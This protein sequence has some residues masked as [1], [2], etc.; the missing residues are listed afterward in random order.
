MPDKRINNLKLGLFTLAGLFF[1]VISLYMIGRDQNL[2]RSN[3]TIKAHFRNAQGIVAGNNIRYA[4]IQV[5][6]VSEVKLI[7][8]TLIEIEMLIDEKAGAKILNNALAAIGTEGLIGNKVINLYPGEGSANPIR[9]GDLLQV[10]TKPDTDAMLETLALTND[11]AATL[12]ADLVETVNRINKS[13]ALWKLL[14]DDSLAVD[15]RASLLNIR[16]ASEKTNHLVSELNSLVAD[17]KSGQGTAGR[18]LVDTALAVQLSG[19]LS[20]L[21]DAAS[22]AAGLTGKLDELLLGIQKDLD[23]GKGPA[24]AVL[25]D[26]SM[27]KKLHNSLTNIEK[28]TFAFNEN[29]EALKHSFLFRGYFRKQLKKQQKSLEDSLK[30]P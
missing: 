17:V 7:N 9:E 10:R 28:S 14:N 5:G 2:F 24:N 19:A 6:T 22:N 3:I 16:Q 11:N 26:S 25:K 29:M 27:V 23:S 20:K 30:S 21:D 8:D 4:G 1:L 12:S 13:T 18:L 15:L